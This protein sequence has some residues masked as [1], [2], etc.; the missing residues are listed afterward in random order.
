MPCNYAGLAGA[1]MAKKATP[2]KQKEEKKEPT[3]KDMVEA[4]ITQGNTLETYPS[5]VTGEAKDVVFV[6]TPIDDLNWIM[7]GG[8]PL[9]RI[10]QI[11]GME[12]AG[13]TSLMLLF[14]AAM[15]AY[16]AALNIARGV[17]YIDVEHALDTAYARQLGVLLQQNGHDNGMLISQPDSAE[18]AL[19]LLDQGVK[20]GLFGMVIIDSDA[21]LTPQCELDGDVGDSHTAVRERLMAQT[22]RKVA[23]A[24]NRNGTVICDISQMRATINFMGNGPKKGPTGGNAIKFYSSIRL[25][26]YR[27][28]GVTDPGTGLEVA[29]LIGVKAAKNKVA[30]PFRERGIEVRFGRGFYIE[31]ALFKEAIA[32]KIVIQA[33]A[34]YSFGA[35]EITKKG[36][37]ELKPTTFAQG[38]ENALVILESNPAF[39]KLLRKL[40]DQVKTTGELP[41]PLTLKIPEQEDTP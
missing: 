35:T 17:L 18:A 40:I 5:I 37:V 33:G 32:T 36:K 29:N 19:R 39:V 28:Q 16:Y 23:G 20:S 10:I 22:L 31:G 3:H 25:F 2:K 6:P 9:G 7:G 26:L 30:P 13:K 27:I 4:F 41:D 14:A 1:C 21:S 24:A 12:A 11:W 15:P 38:R 8:I 34:Y